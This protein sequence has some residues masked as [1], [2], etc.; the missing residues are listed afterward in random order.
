[1]KDQYNHRDTIV[2]AAQEETHVY[3]GDTGYIVIRQKDVHGE[4]V[5]VF[6]TPGV[7]EFVANKMIELIPLATEA[8]EEWVNEVTE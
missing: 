3:V 5:L 1:M 8:R 2:V 6:L 7:I 4:D